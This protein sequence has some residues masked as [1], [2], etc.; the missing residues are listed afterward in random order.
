MPRTP[1]GDNHHGQSKEIENKPISLGIVE[2]GIVL[3]LLDLL[4]FC[5]VFVQFRYFFVGAST[6]EETTGLTFAVYARRGF[7]DW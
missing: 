4:F 5:F 2:I 7:F 3:G 1:H 6:V